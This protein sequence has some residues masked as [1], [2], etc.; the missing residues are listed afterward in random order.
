VSFSPVDSHH[1]SLSDSSVF[2]TMIGIGN[3]DSQSEFQLSDTVLEVQAI[4]DP[5]FDLIY[6]G[7]VPPITIHVVSHF[8]TL[9]LLLKKYDCVIQIK[10]VNYALNQ[11]ITESPNHGT[12][13]FVLGAA[14]EDVELC[15]KSLRSD[16]GYRWTDAIKDRSSLDERMGG[17]RTFDLRALNNKMFQMIPPRYTL[18]LMRA[19]WPQKGKIPTSTE[20]VAEFRRLLGE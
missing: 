5:F 20:V 16:T 10:I 12:H 1:R 11:F 2:R 14:I 7:E 19:Q 4:L 8:H 15:G 9:S 6:R 13:I 18:A 3:T 17:Q